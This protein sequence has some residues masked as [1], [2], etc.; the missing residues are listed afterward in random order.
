MS[1]LGSYLTSRNPAL[2]ISGQGFGKYSIAGYDTYAVAYSNHEDPANPTR[3]IMLSRI[4][5]P[6]MTMTF[7]GDPETFDKQMP[8]AQKN[9]RLNKNNWNQITS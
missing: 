7:S 3:N 2:T 9:G 4:G 8:T 6:Q 5:T 1:S